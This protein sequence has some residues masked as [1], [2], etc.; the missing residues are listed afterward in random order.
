MSPSSLTK[1]ISC[2]CAALLV[3]APF[4]HAQVET[5]PRRALDSNANTTANNPPPTITTTRLTNEPVIRIG[6]ATSARSVTISTAAPA[7]NVTTG[8]SENAPPQPLAAA[9]VRIEPRVLAPLPVEQTHEL[10]RVEIAVV[11]SAAAA[12]ALARDVRSLTGDEANVVHDPTT[13]AWR[14]RV[15]SPVEQAEAEE[16]RGRLEEAGFAAVSVVNENTPRSNVQKVNAS[17][18]RAAQSSGTQIKDTWAAANNR[19][20]N[21]VSA[22]SNTRANG[23][24]RLAARVSLSTRGLVIYAAGAGALLEARTPVVLGSANEQR[25]PVRFNE[26]PYRGRIEVFT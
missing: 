5:R 7:L 2:L 11:E 26:K 18:Q 9:R 6:L 25:A 17:D 8:T 1:L 23:N 4:A 13:N 3:C 16:L 22:N 21:N 19:S 12:E 14:V 20:S 10:Y 24:V 15:G